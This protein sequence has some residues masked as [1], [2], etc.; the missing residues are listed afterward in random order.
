M[1]RDSS[2]S[3]CLSLWVY[4]YLG[5]AKP[6]GFEHWKDSLLYSQIPRERVQRTPRVGGRGI[7]GSWEWK[8]EGD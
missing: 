3:H 2:S 6:T 7:S 5:M 1:E 8:G 4:D